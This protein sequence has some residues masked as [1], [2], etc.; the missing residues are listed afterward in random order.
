MIKSTSE[1]VFITGLGIISPIGSNLDKV[2]SNLLNGVSGVSKIEQDW[3]NEMDI[4]IAAQVLELTTNYITNIQARRYD[5]FAQFAI[6]AARQAWNDANIKSIDNERLGVVIGTG[7]GGI[8]TLLNSYDTLK[9]RGSKRV[10]PFTVPMLMPNSASALVG[11]ELG[12][13]GGIHTPVSA[14]ASGAEAILHGYKLIKDNVCDV[15]VVGGAEAVIHPLPISA[16]NNMMAMSRRNDTPALASRPFDKLRDGFVLGEGSGVLILERESH[17][18]KRNAR[19]YCELLRG[20]STSDA[21]HIASPEPNGRDIQRAISLALGINNISKNDICH[22]NPHATSTMQGDLA[23]S[24]ALEH[25]FTDALS[26]IYVSATKSVTG[27]LLGAAGAVE[28]IFTILS[29]YK[30]VVP[31]TINVKQLDEQIK[32][33]IAFESSKLDFKGRD[34][35]LNNSFGFGGHNIVL[36]FKRYC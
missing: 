26:N 31:G 5:R 1:K 17:A 22:I 32:L 9:E 7:I 11:I 6:I 23:E 19:I 35:A 16:F 2:W 14:C 4:K 8:I 30:G 13:R 25:V 3:V 28:S 15:V 34:I 12:A 10:S 24:R 33:K 20:A 18:I 36:P 21:Y 29:L 27:H